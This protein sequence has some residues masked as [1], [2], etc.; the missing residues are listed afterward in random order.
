MVDMAESGYA[1]SLCCP[2]RELSLRE[3]AQLEKIMEYEDKDGWDLKID[4]SVARIVDYLRRGIK[5]VNGWP[6]AKVDTTGRS[7]RL[8]CTVTA[9]HG[10]VIHCRAV[11]SAV[12][13][14]IYHRKDI[15]F[16]PPLPSPIQGTLDRLRFD[17]ALKVFLSF[18]EPFW[19]SDTQG[20]ICAGSPCPEFWFQPRM[21][22]APEDFDAAFT[23]ASSPAPFLV[24]L[25]ATND[26]ARGLTSLTDDHLLKV[27]LGQLDEMYASEGNPK[28]A[29]RAF[30]S[31]LKYDWAK[32]DFVH[33][34][35]SSP[36]AGVTMA[37]RRAL[38]GPHHEGRLYLCGEHTSPSFASMH[39]ALDTGEAVAAE[40]S[41]A[42]PASSLKT[43]L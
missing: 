5:V 34:G 41:K 25:F 15:E 13:L 33:G 20:V 24:T 21:A 28:P 17:P 9:R 23:G 36:T 32:A 31:W 22:R 6:V 40:V 1:N 2:I 18:T 29:T 16:N 39:G 19:P 37:H 42:L 27:I 12:P 4:G 35:Y 7:S 10:A 26:A 14:S 8:G 11:V 38:W 30:H 3:T 43:K